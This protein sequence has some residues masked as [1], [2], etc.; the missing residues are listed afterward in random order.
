MKKIIRTYVTLLAGVISLFIPATSLFAGE[1]IT[2]TGYAFITSSINKDIFRTR[3]IENA[4]QKIVRSPQDINSFSLVENGKVLIDQIQ[5][6]SDVKILQY[7]IIGVY[8]K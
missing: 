8:R 3:A 4:L 5:T 2:S 1:T 7:E 6:R